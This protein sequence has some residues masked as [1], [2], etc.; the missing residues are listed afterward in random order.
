MKVLITQSNYIP[1]KGY[2]DAIARADVLVLYDEMQY[3]KRDW[4]NRNKI[5]L[6]N[7][8]Q[9]LTIPVQVKGKFHQKINETKVTDGDWQQ[10]HWNSLVHAYKKTP[11]FDDF[12]SEL[13]HL[14]LNQRYEL[15]SVVN[16]TF[17]EQIC[18]WLQIETEIRWSKEFDLVGDKSQK[19]AEHLQ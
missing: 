11:F 3:T 17:I 2:F 12:A 13:E 15:L 9:W 16:R 19:T 18:T 8:L 10:K 6:P 5:K 7:G 4:R 14:Y 1:W